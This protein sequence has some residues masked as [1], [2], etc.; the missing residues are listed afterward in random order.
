[1]IP[2]ES[3]SSARLDLPYLQAGQMQKHVTLNE[4]LTRLDALVQCAVVSWSIAE[5]PEAP[6]DGALYILPNGAT[7][8]AWSAMPPGG[9]A[10][11]EAGGWAAIMAP[12]GLRAF[13]L[14]EQR[15]VVLGE[16]GWTDVGANP[17]RLD[18]LAGLGVGTASDETNA[19]AAKLNSALWS[20]RTEGEGGTGDLRYVLNK[21][22]GAKTLSLLFQSGWS[23]RAEIGLVGDD[24]LVLK[25]SPDGAAWREAL[26]VDRQ[27]G[28]LAFSVMDALLRPAAQNVLTAFETSPGRARA[29]LIDDLISALEAAGVWTRLTALYVTAAHDEQAAGL[30]L[31]TPGLHDLTPVNGP[32]FSEDLGWSGDGVDAWLD[33]GLGA[34]ALADGGT[35]VAAGV[36]VTANPSPGT[37]Q[38]PLGPVDGDETLSMAISPSTGNFSA[39]VGT[40]TL[41]AFGAAPAVTGHFCVSR[42]STTHVSG[43]HDGVL[44]GAAASAFTGYAGGST[45]L[46]R[47]LGNLHSGTLAAAWLGKDLDAGQAAALH[48]ALAA[49][50]GETGAV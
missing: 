39:R 30:N 38:F 28:R 50:L 36:W 32:A 24:D 21:E 42:T 9:L 7:G 47:R 15:L 44:I 8:A 14:D 5:Q 13:V 2:A 3:Q 23:G 6:D 22:D 27:T 17:D 31:K 35:G 37:S 48:G 4:A 33:T 10:R 12:Q 11:F 43:Y 46:F 16:D 29:F 41:A 49:Y 26:R 19:F 40:A 20:A 25:V 34:S 1:M 18:D 45:A